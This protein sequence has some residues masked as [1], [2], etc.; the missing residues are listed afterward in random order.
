MKI[1]A[2]VPIKNEAWI[3]PTFFSSIK[4]IADTIIILDDKSTDN[5][6]EIAKNNNAVV[7]PFEQKD[8]Q[9]SMSL[10][11]Q[12]LLEEGRKRKGTHFIWLDADEA[13]TKPFIDY[14]KN[15]M[16]QMKPRQKLSMQWLAL[17]KSPFFY[18]DDNT[19]WSNNY[20]DFVACDSL[21]YTFHNQFLSEARTPGPNTPEHTIKIKPEHGAVLHFQFVP[22][23]KF[24]IK[25]AWYRCLE[26][27][28]SPHN[29]FNINQRYK[30]GLDNQE[31]HLTPV[32]KEWI[33]NI[34]IPKN[35]YE[36]APSW[37]LCEIIKF[38]DQYHIKFF[39]P[40]Q[41]WHIP[42]LYDEFIKRVGRK[43]KPI[44]KHPIPVR[45]KRKICSYIPQN[46]KNKIKQYYE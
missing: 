33:K 14:A 31:T 27:I 16:Q 39:E 23:N 28:E 4:Q 40:L 18:K 42:E 36:L 21:N 38:F 20:K 44:L 45:I 22:W 1:I 7:I 43:P 26:L 3:L 2:L 37:H 12:L 13:F 32:P 17:W 15:I 41:I 29:A 19:V 30:I 35:T 8:T 9:Q 46:I 6:V 10:R 25:Q 24:Q 11:R 5:S 34:V